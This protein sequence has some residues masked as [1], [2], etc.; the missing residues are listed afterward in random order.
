MK[1]KPS[2]VEKYEMSSFFSAYLVRTPFAGDSL[3]NPGVVKAIADKQI[4]QIDLVYT[5]FRSSETFDQP[6]LNQQRFANLYKI[7]P[8]LFRNSAIMWQ[9]VN[10]TGCRDAGSCKDF[11]HGFVLYY[12]TIKS[13]GERETELKTISTSF[14]KQV[15]IDTVLVP[16]HKYIGKYYVPKSKRKLARGIT[17]DEAGRNRTLVR[18]Y[19]TSERYR[20]IKTEQLI[21]ITD[22]SSTVVRVGRRLDTTVLAALNR[23]TQWSNMQIVVDV[24]GSMGPYIQQVVD[25]IVMQQNVERVDDFV[26]FQDGDHKPDHIKEIGKTDGIYP[27]KASNVVEIFEKMQT[28]MRNGYGGDAEEND[29]EA[30]LLGAKLN[31]EAG[32]VILIADNLANMRDLSLMWK[33]NR[34]VHIVLCGNYGWVNTQYLDLAYF[35]KGSIHTMEDDLTELYRMSEGAEISIGAARYVVRN[36]GFHQIW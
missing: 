5:D 20:F 19:D 33:L 31:P 34:P 11:F 30:L 9:V 18:M 6:E 24:T 14:I 27:V 1:L 36:G 15:K 17:Y 22:T 32:E 2:A 23:N 12:Q 7:A 25:W 8:Q 28:A 26:F 13:G 3:L 35:T 4:I 29:I 16:R 10:Q 21:A